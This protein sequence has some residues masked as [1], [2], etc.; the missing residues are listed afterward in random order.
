MSSLIGPTFKLYFTHR[1]IAVS[2]IVGIGRRAPELT[3][4]VLRIARLPQ[5]NRLRQSI[6]KGELNT[7]YNIIRILKTSG[8]TGRKMLVRKNKN[9]DQR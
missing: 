6:K 3:H 8:G 4:S 1:H 2:W 9:C 7:V 5:K